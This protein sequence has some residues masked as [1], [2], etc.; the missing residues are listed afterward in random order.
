MTL[1]VVCL[2]LNGPQD[3][4]QLLIHAARR[5]D[6]SMFEY[7]VEH[8]AVIS[9]DEEMDESIVAM[10]RRRQNWIN[11]ATALA[12]RWHVPLT[13]MRTI[14]EYVVGYNWAVVYERFINL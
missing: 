10:F 14:H 6:L 5:N 1:Q 3:N 4:A 9:P 8:G 2:T 13:A 7:L 11:Q 12:H